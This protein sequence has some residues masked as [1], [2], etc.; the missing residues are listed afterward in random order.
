MIKDRI[1]LEIALSKLKLMSANDRN[2]KLEQY[3][4]SSELAGMILWK[5]FLDGA[6]KGKVV[7]D[8]GCGNGV[9]GIGALLLGAKKVIFLD[10]DVNSID[11]CRENVMFVGFLKKSKFLVSD[12]SDFSFKVDTVVMNPPFGVKVRKADKIFLE[13]AFSFS[14]CVYSLHKIESSDF[15]NKISSENGF[16]VLE[17]LPINMKIFRS[18]WFH[19]KNFKEIA[20]GLWVMKRK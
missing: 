12:V 20:I 11:L 13:K 19:K 16:K 15:V 1:A 17:V 9:F 7:A 18:Y 3:Q 2:I 14:N 6:I 8:F 5:A 4:S 10:V